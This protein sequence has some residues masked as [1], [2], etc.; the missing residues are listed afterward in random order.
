MGDGDGTGRLL[1]RLERRAVGGM[2]HV[3]HEPDAVPLLDHLPAHAGQP[4]VVGLVAARRQKR[5]VVV[6]QLHEA[7]A[8][9]VDDLDEA[10]I[11]LDRRGVLEAEEDRRAPFGP[12]A[13]HVV[14]RAALEDQ[15]GKP[16]EPA[17]PGL[18]VLHRL[19]EF[20]V[21]GD[22]DVDRV[23]APFAHLAE[24]LLRP[25]AYCRQSMR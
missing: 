9:R 16:L 4:G 7:R 14:A 24:N 22:G 11:V 15:I 25:V 18:D 12:R 19:P 8:E 10:D 20:L 21:V 23:H 5:L 2:A 13:A 6:A 3:H 17:I 1:D